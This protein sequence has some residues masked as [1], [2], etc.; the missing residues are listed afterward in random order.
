MSPIPLSATA[1]HEAGHALVGWLGGADL[2]FVSIV[3]SERALGVT[4]CDIPPG[5]LRHS[6]VHTIPPAADEALRW[7]AGPL[8]EHLYGGG[9]WVRELDREVD[10]AIRRYGTLGA[11]EDL[12]GSA[13]RLLRTD[14]VREAIGEVRRVLLRDRTATG[15]VLHPII[16]TRLGRRK[17]P[18]SAGPSPTL[19]PNREF[20]GASGPSQRPRI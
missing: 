3:R 8:A 6:L 16:E 10:E 7:V 18:T 11:A 20:T 19:Q 12:F 9:A 1:T 14:A 5:R 15:R 2:T 17:V 4:R 13:F